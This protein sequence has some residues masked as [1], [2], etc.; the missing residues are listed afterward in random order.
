MQLVNCWTPHHPFHGDLRADRR[1]QQRV[2]IFQALQVS[3]YSAE[4]QIVS[5]YRF[6]QLFA[7]K[8]LQAAERAFTGA[9]AGSKQSVQWS[10]ER[11]DVVGA[12][13]LYVA[14]HVHA[15]GAQSRKRN[16]GGNIAIPPSYDAV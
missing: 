6:N 4:E 2:A 10:R 5:V 12:R 9:A 14:N 11:A 1:N 15:N 3:A 13:A 7:A 8:M 16:S